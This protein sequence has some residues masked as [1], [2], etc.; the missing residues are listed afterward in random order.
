MSDFELKME[1]LDKN[2]SDDL[3]EQEKQAR[4]TRREKFHVDTRSGKERRSGLDRRKSLRF[5]PD[6]RSGKDRRASP[7]DPWAKNI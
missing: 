7:S 5:E 6:R 1:P 2:L 3:A 4:P